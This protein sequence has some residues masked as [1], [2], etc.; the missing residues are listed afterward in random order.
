MLLTDQF[1]CTAQ[2]E[3]ER[4]LTTQELTAV[5]RQRLLARTAILNV[6]RDL[7]NQ[8]RWSYYNRRYTLRTVAADTSATCEY[9]HTGGSSERLLTLTNATLPTDGTGEYYRVVIDSVHYDIQR[10]LTSTTAVLEQNNNPGADIAASTACTVY[11]AYYPFPIGFRKLCHVWD[12]EQEREMI[13]VGDD[14]QH[15]QSISV[16][17]DPS[18]SEYVSIGSRGEALSALALIFIPPPSEARTYDIMY[19][20]A[21]QPISTWLYDDGKVSTS[22]VTATLSDGG[23]TKSNMVGSVIR[24]SRNIAHAP[25]PLVGG[26]DGVDN[27]FHSQR[28]I[29][30]VDSSTALTMNASVD[31]LTSVRYTISDPIDIENG[32]MLLAFQKMCDSEYAKLLRIDPKERAFLDSDAQV[33][34]RRAQE[35]DQRSTYARRSSPM[36]DKFRRPTIT[37]E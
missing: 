28:I 7:P 17:A 5:G 32:A 18:V 14:E 37:T 2:D 36:F 4:L 9:D 11:R 8:S 15:A 3:F 23:A 34:L 30:A 29:L 21:P 31:T 6:L 16:F 10:V 33:H 26:L 35:N 1:V 19:E 22:T 27:P 12:V 24:F 25:T 20:A 13:V